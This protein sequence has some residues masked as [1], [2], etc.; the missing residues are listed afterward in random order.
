MKS[1]QNLAAELTRNFDVAAR[2]ELLYDEP[3]SKYTTLQIGGPAD[4][5]YL[6]GSEQAL[7]CFLGLAAE[8][9]LMVYYMGQGSNLL[10]ADQG[11][12]GA[13]VMLGEANF[14]KVERKDQMIRAQAGA[15]LP[16]V[17]EFAAK[18][19][20]SGLE[21]AAGIPGSVGGAAVVNAGAYDGDMANVVRELEV[22]ERDGVKTRLTGKDLAYRY[23]GSAA[24]GGELLVSEVL[25]GLRRDDSGRVEQRIAEN[26]KN[27]AAGQPLDLP[28]AGCAFK[29]PPGKEAWRLIEAVGMKGMT[30]GF[31]QVSELHTNFIIN[32]GGASADDYRQLLEETETKVEDKLGVRLEREVITL[33][34]E[35]A[36]D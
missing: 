36:S 13:V 23:R 28:S 6:P 27:R 29:N 2:G 32:L 22:F 1:W 34:F 3:L 10:I 9:G 11:Y 30:R 26:A 14:G 12:R 21:F 5:I 24:K 7:S 31:A 4:L 25:L 33:G 18:E 17:V 19:E 20:L 35:N 15:P 8:S 16:K